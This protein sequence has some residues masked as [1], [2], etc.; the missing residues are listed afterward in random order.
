MTMV[1]VAVDQA[2]DELTETSAVQG[3]GVK[4]FSATKHRDREAIR[5]A[6][7]RDEVKVV[8]PHRRK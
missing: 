1:R 6:F 2:S 3:S 8:I 4:V 5:R 7:V